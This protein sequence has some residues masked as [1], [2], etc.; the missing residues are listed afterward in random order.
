MKTYEFIVSLDVEKKLVAPSLQE[1]TQ[2]LENKLN[3]AVDNQRTIDDL[4]IVGFNF[5]ERQVKKLCGSD[6]PDN[7]LIKKIQDWLLD[8]VEN[9]KAP[10]NSTDR[11]DEII[12]GRREC[13]LGLLH[14]INGLIDEKIKLLKQESKDE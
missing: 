4:K 5:N 6:L 9:S 11:V 12:S 2:D 3:D 13:A 1:A 10:S 7:D 8:E 14:Y